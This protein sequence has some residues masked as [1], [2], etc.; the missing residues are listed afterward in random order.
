[1]RSW[2]R[3]LIIEGL[4][5]G[6]TYEYSNCYFGCRADEGLKVYN[7]EPSTDYDPEHRSTK[8]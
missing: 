4:L 6:L 3:K 1:M 2:E 7:N 5:I 8:I